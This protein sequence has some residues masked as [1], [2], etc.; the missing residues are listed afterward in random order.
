MGWINHKDIIVITLLI[1]QSEIWFVI[2]YKS[3]FNIYYAE[4]NQSLIQYL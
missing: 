1:F 2:L 4:P 3:F